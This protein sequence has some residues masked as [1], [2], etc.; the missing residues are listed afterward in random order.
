[1]KLASLRSIQRD[2][3]LVVV[4]RDLQHIAEAGP[5]LPTLQ[6]ALDDWGRADPLLQARYA[7]LNAG[8]IADAIPINVDMLAA[9]LPRA[10]LF[11]DGSAYYYHMSVVRSAR[12]AKVPDDF[13]DRP[14]LYQGTSDPMLG[15]TESLRLTE[16]EALG[17]DVEAEIAIITDDVPMGVSVED[18]GRHIKL[19][20]LLNDY[21]LRLV[22]PPE[23]ARGFG[24]VQGKCVSTM[25]PIAVTPDELGDAWDSNLL[26]GRYLVHINGELLG[27][28]SPGDDASFNYAQLICHGARTRELRAGTVIGAGALANR[29]HDRHGSGCIAEERAH[30]QLKDGAP[31]MRY[32]RFGDRVRM[33]MFDADGQTIFGAIDQQIERYV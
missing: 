10:Y 2:G 22:I 33:E 12:G 23:L 14:L 18:A 30:E 25:G 26:H 5:D 9:P 15:P 4:S 21:S 16:D 6:A 8:A 31:Q 7:A 1:M 27:D 24:F 17:I 11:L 20:T 13:F 3:K 29:D 32:L 28:L 19:V